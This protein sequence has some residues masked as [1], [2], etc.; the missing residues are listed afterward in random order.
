MSEPSN[1]LK[2]KTVFE[3]I[4]ITTVIVSLILVWQEIKQNRILAEINYEMIITQNRIMANQTMVTQPGVWVRGCAKDS[5]ST[6]EKVIFRAMIE[7]KNALA[8]YKWVKALRLKDSPTMWIEVADFVGFLHENPGARAVW[9]DMEGSLVA[10]RQKQGT[11]Y[12]GNDWY[13]WVKGGLEK[14]DQLEHG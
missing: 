8:F 6:E 5:L 11:P 13:E 14:L 4:G 9:M 12:T 1:L 10:S 3:I 2:V 7:D